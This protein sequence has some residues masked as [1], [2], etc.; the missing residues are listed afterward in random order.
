MMR[1]L[2]FLSLL[3]FAFPA[4]AEEDLLASEGE[5]RVPLSQYTAMLQQ[6]A[7]DPRPAP[8]DYA[9]GQSQVTVSISEEG[10]RHQARVDIAFFIE[11]FEDDWTLVPILP[12]GSAL[13]HASVDGRPVQLVEGP[14]G[15]SW[16]SETAGTVTMRLSYGIEAKRYDDGFTLALAVPRSPATLL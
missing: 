13:R 6:L 10:G 15:L 1:V 9:I 8:A 4:F 5:V 12:T 16:V 11:T 3:L 7:G 2:I 14:A